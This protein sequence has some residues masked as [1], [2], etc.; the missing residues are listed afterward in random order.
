VRMRSGVARVR[1]LIIG[2]LMAQLAAR[3]NDPPALVPH[4]EAIFDPL[5]L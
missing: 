5:N 2:E 1:G 3:N 4:K